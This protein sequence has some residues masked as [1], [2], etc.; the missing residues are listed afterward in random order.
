VVAAEPAS[1]PAVVCEENHVRRKGRARVAGGRGRAGIVAT[2]VLLAAFALPAVAV[3]AQEAGP[4]DPTTSAPGAPPAAAD[5][6]TAESTPAG[7]TIAGTVWRDGNPDGERQPDEESIAGVELTLIGDGTE[8]DSSRSDDDGTYRFAEVAPG[9]YVVRLDP[10]EAHGAS[11]P[12]KAAAREAADAPLNA[13]GEVVDGETGVVT[14][15]TDPVE[16]APGSEVVLEAGLTEASTQE[17]DDPTTPVPPEAT[18]PAADDAVVGPLATSP[19]N[20]AI[21]NAQS[22]LAYVAAGENLDVAF[23]KATQQGGA[24]DA[25][26]T[27][28]GPGFTTQTCTNTDGAGI[29]TACT[30]TD[31]TSAESGIWEIEYA[32]AGTTGDRY[33]WSIN[34]QSGTTTIPGRVYSNRYLMAQSATTAV[35]NLWYQSEQGYR[36]QATYQNY[37]GIDSVI[38]ADATGVALDGTCVSAYQSRDLT[39][40]NVDPNLWQ[41]PPG[42]CG[43]P[44]KI[45]F[46]APAADLPA[47][48]TRWDGTTT[49][50]APPPLLPELSNLTFTPDSP[51]VRSGTF[52]FVVANFTGQLTV[53]VDV[54]NDGDYDDPEDRSLPAAVAQA[55]TVSVPFDGN[56]GTGAPI[57][58]FQDLGARV[59]ITQAGEI[60]FAMQ[61][62]ERRDTI[63]VTALNGPDEGSS[64]IYWNDTNLVVAGRDC[65]T[66]LFDG[67]AGVSSAAG[68]HGWTCANN[69][70]NG[71]NGSWGDQRAI[72]DWAFQTVD[73]SV[74]IEIAGE[75]Q[76]AFE[77]PPDGM[78]FQYPGNM[79]PTQ[80]R[81]I[82]MVTG[83]D[84]P[85][86]VFADRR[87]NGV[88]YNVLDGYVYGWDNDLPG[89]VRIGADG[90][91]DELRVPD[92]VPG[93]SSYPVG[94]IDE[95]GQYWIVNSV[96]SGAA[97][98]WFQ[99]DLAP[100]SPTYM[101][102]V[103]DGTVS[104]GDV[105]GFGGSGDWARV[106]T[107]ADYLYRVMRSGTQWSLFGFNRATGAHENL[108]ALTSP[109]LPTTGTFGAAFADG[110]FLYVSHNTT[111]EIF[112]VDVANAT[113]A[114]FAE[115][116]PSDNNDGARCFQAA[117][118]I[119][120][121]DAPESYGTLIADDGP[122]HS[123][124][125]YD[126]AT[127]TA[128]VMLGASIDIET[129]G[130]ASPN[131]DGDDTTEIDDEDG[132]AFNPALGYP[133]PTLRTGLDPSTLSPVENT[134]QVTA[135]ANGFASVWVDWNADGDFDDAGEQVANA[136]PVTPG[137]N[138]VTFTQE[139]NPPSIFTTVRVRYSTDADA[140]AAPT[141]PAPNGEV[142]D[143]RVL[144]ERYLQPEVCVDSTATHY[145]FTFSPPVDL[146]GNGNPPSTGR[147][148]NVSVIEGVPVDMFVETLTG[149][150]QGGGPNGYRAG[151][152]GAGSD[153]DDALW[154]ISGAPTLIRYTFYVAGTTTPVPV[155][156]AFTVNDMDGSE[157]ARFTAADLAAFSVAQGSEVEIVEDG[158][159]VEFLGM[160]S[161]S[162][163]PGSRFQFVLEGTSTIE[164]EWRGFSN[165][166]F[167]LDGDGDLAIGDPACDDFGDAPDEYGT[168]LASDGARH[169][170]VPGLILGDQ[171]DFDP[172]GQPNADADGD[173][174]NRQ[175][176]EDGVADPISII[177]GQPTTVTVSATN[178]TG[179]DATLAGWIDLDGN[180]AFEPGERATATV[181]ANSGAGTYPL[182]FPP[183]TATATT[184]ARFRLFPGVVADPQPTG[185][186]AGG[187]VED[188]SV[189]AALVHYE[190]T[191]DP[192]DVEELQP[193]TTFTYTVTVSNLGSVPLT[194]LS[195]T[196]DLTEVVDDATFVTNSE[197]ATT[198]TVAFVPPD[199]ITW[200]G[201]LG[202]GEVA[203][204]SYQVTIDDP[205]TGDAILLNGVVGNG[206]GSNCPPPGPSTD[207]D[208]FEQIPQPLIDTAK[209]LLGPADPEAGDVV[210][211]QF[212]VTNE[213]A[214]P[215]FNV[216]IS[217][218]LS[219]VLDDAAYNGDAFTDLGAVA[220]DPGAQAVVWSIATLNP[221]ETATITYSVTVN[222]ADAL[223]D[224]ILQNALLAPDCPEP[225]IFDPSDPDFDPECV[226]VTDIAAWTSVKTSDA[227]NPVMAGDEVTYTI[228]VANTGNVALDDPANLPA[229]EDDLTAVVDDAS[230]NDD[231]D[232]GGQGTLSY[233]APVLAWEGELAIGQT[234][235][236]TYTVTVNAA[237]A[238]GDGQ[239]L[240]AVTGA[241][242][243]PDPAITDPQAPGFNADCVVIEDVAAWT[244]AKTSNANDPVLPGEAVVYTLTV[245]NTGN[246]A[247]TDPTELPPVEDDLTNVLDDA[248]YNDDADSGGQGAVSYAEPVL[249][250]Q[251]TLAVDQVVVITYSVTVNGADALGDGQL[252]NAVTGTPNCPAPAVT[253]PE[254]PGFNPDCVV[255]S[256]IAAWTSVKTSDADDPVLP[257]GTVAYTITVTNTGN[258]ALDD[259]GDLPALDDDLTA[260]LDDAA[261]NNDADSGGDGSLSYAA[262]I[263]SWTGELAV[264]QV[265]TITYSVTVNGA[266]A[267][268]DGQLLNA[269]TG[270]PNCPDPAI[271]DPEAP[272]FNADCVVIANIAAWTSVKTSDAGD[273]VLPEGTVAYTITVTNTG[274]VALDDPGDLPAIEDDLTA[275]LDD[276]A[277]NSDASSGG[278]GMVSFTNPV[279][280]WEGALAVGQVVTITYSVTVN[281]ADALGD[282]Q[283]LNAV[284][285]A[286][287]CP[288]P[289]ITDPEAPEFN[290]DCVVIANIAAW[291]SVKTSDASGP[292]D[293]G[294][295]ITYTVTV[296]NTGN[297]ALDDPGGL[298]SI[299]D[300][301]TAVLDDAVYN[302][303]ADS[304]GQG[305]VAYAAPVLS[306]QGALAIDQVVTITYSVTVNDAGTLGDGVLANA[307]VGAPNCPDPAVTDPSAPGFDADCAVVQAVR[308]FVAIKTSNAADPV[309]P[310]DVVTYT[311]EVVNDGG[312]DLVAPDAA[313]IDDD[314][315]AVLDDAT[316][317]DGSAMATTG[318]ATFSDSTLSWVGELLVGQT[319][320]ITYSVTVNNPNEGD[321]LLRNAVAT[322]GPMCQP[323]T[324]TDPGDPNFDERCVVADPVAGV[325]YEKTIIEPA[326]PTTLGPGDTF[327]YRVVVT[328]VGQADLTGLS[329][330]D[331][332]SGVL[333]HATYLDNA[334]TTAGTVS[335]SAPVLT[336]TG[337]LDPGQ[338]AVV[339]YSLRLNPDAP[340]GTALRNAVVGTGPGSNC[341]P[342]AVAPP[343]VALAQAS[344]GA[345][346]AGAPPAGASRPLAFTG[347][348]VLWLAALGLALVAGGTVAVRS[349]RSRRARRR[350]LANIE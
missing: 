172:N 268:G 211:Y 17:G 271:T 174:L 257:D 350:A 49:W 63:S 241:P 130:L 347:T 168:L 155:N 11:V 176:D 286:P 200:S 270:A 61:D 171:I 50:L 199:Q 306:W 152:V 183:G 322:N 90:S 201:D 328:N 206:P 298:P 58:P 283:L 190:K 316:F 66:P 104:G 276:A 154:N 102:A 53:G 254:A 108:G 220:F 121:G 134:V 247:F 302:N 75:V 43:D 297:V 215:A 332:L 232:S 325:H 143:Y 114:R 280:S 52:E 231:A 265:V 182:S 343:C 65:V 198:G 304:G 46:E 193:G 31:L 209:T 97:V 57:S 264:G 35:L 175:D 105:T 300:D 34:V 244:A 151:A 173:D 331:D 239:L 348:T 326:D 237:D 315:S 8:L 4:D 131:A 146:T 212:T 333:L 107:A 28:R 285:G 163:D 324:I 217:D 147:Y 92:G 344:R 5:T 301:L 89:V 118:P 296:T 125:G 258:V 51:T 141:G 202:V 181:L 289:A 96:G 180:G 150:T 253:D 308:S 47:T 111:G 189:L 84:S 238:M 292:S 70:N 282:G 349:V 279:L 204:V 3:T 127:N 100:G 341:P 19:P 320:T 224:G 48:A 262:P 16:V 39:G 249:S 60:H 213:G 156:A 10:P 73:V 226:T 106:P 91:V 86:D 187:E 345:P 123:I 278:V 95:N 1:A 259:P 153:P 109:A 7:G 93:G 216:Q 137:V 223:G 273:P 321:F 116:P 303:D 210:S 38:S 161:H 233:A 113:V 207:P 110:E 243:C 313:E 36:Y 250:W 164:I 124:G 64:T 196:D 128:P 252:V 132:V 15:E 246:V 85:G 12:H 317:N 281:G 329:F 274:N 167:G 145:A 158:A 13:F 255:I 103:A 136:Q 29:G 98:R 334:S 148:E 261:Y 307:V 20:S 77:C 83:A 82:D 236:I 305:T 242:N 94:D 235:T 144:V 69:A 219:A 340:I 81:L 22:L 287:N 327:T 169:T 346:P 14:V 339:T 245:T 32:H 342:G 266:D 319:A 76:P 149:R 26:F 170:V 162:G 310:G 101:T 78:L 2:A 192:N 228:A 178:D 221:T 323:P 44:F 330:T 191:A 18:T 59:S 126:P 140:I 312:T 72:D 115:G 142:E 227:G 79:P 9:T 229:I 139:D 248:S 311:I 186:A 267:L 208:C 71:I 42:Q 314:L 240:N 218:D 295:A 122:R 157:A 166:G 272:E 37:N 129:E 309:T 45:F 335:Y 179:A 62:V 56:D 112:R 184:Y 318:T 185:A 24:G 120:F 117:I 25:T 41:P 205:I 294:D 263:L 197:T 284:T 80:V 133:N 54:N 291:T 299:Q 194:G 203:T 55:G 230:Y 160:G 251:G 67:T 30:F 88:A 68:V 214:A 40:P 336:W 222:G 6:A 260:V 87:I 275:V 269:V 225:P 338:T 177:A 159:F 74:E 135:S 138:D 27:V 337:D 165:S 195:F 99:V 293:P 277:Y 33:T 188:Y 290:A 288:D 119:D 234:V 256:N 23:T 21:R